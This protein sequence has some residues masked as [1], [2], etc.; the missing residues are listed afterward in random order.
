V[1]NDERSRH[2]EKARGARREARPLS[3]FP[4]PIPVDLDTA[5]AVQEAALEESGSSICGW[6]VGLIPIELRQRYRSERLAGPV[7]IGIQHYSGTGGLIDVPVFAGGFAAI[8]AEVAFLIGHNVPAA[9]A[10]SEIELS[11]AIASAHIAFELAG[12]PLKSIMDL[13]PGAII[14]DQAAPFRRCCFS[15][16]TCRRAVAVFAKE[17]GSSQ[18]R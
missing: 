3:T 1:R 11:K 16:S 7:S 2:R 6:K 14:A 17:T 5:Y 18:A 9:L 4:R 12:S 8:E 13:G 10:H 15:L